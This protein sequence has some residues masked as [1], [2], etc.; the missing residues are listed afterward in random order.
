MWASDIRRVARDGDWI[1][2]RSYSAIGDLIV[3]GTSGPEISHASIY[4]AE[5]GTAI[6]AVSSGVREVPLD[7]LLERNRIAIIVRPHDL[8]AHQRRASVRRARSVIGR[9]FDT[10]GMFGLE[11][12]K[13][14][15]C[16]ELVVWASGLELDDLVITP[17]SLIEHGE[18]IY[19]SGNRES[20]EVQEVALA[21]QRRGRFRVAARSSR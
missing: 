9:S 20:V 16:S 21:Q 5:R 4:D 18:V 13:R 8:D 19:L 11:S 6:E 1:L 17:A 15:Y 2:T 3:A 14:F 12:S 7:D 10:A